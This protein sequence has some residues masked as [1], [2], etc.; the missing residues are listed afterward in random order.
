MHFLSRTCCHVTRRASSSVTRSCSARVAV[1]TGRCRSSC[2]PLVATSW[3][4]PK[5]S[6]IPYYHWSGTV[7]S[8]VTRAWRA[9]WRQIDAQGGSLL[10]LERVKV[11][12]LDVNK[13]VLLLKIQLEFFIVLTHS[14]STDSNSF[15]WWMLRLSLSQSLFCLLL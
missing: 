7:S 8:R 5:S 13:I 14:V 11:K 1:A 4:V 3:R 15:Y 2:W 10:V 12:Q 9:F 6:R